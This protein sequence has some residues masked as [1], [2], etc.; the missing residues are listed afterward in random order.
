[1]SA[2][3]TPHKLR[4]IAPEIY[5]ALDALKRTGWVENDVANPESAKEHTDAL[6][7]LAQ[8][9]ID[10]LTE[11]EK[12]GLL[13]MLEVH[14]WP[15]AVHGDEVILAE[16]PEEEKTRTE[17]KFENEKKA[18][19]EIC[20]GLPQGDDIMRVWMRFETSTD[21]AAVFARELDKYQALEKAFEYEEEQ[22]IALFDE[23][24]VYTQNYIQHP[25]LLQ[26]MKNLQARRSQQK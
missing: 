6:I 13:E 4:T 26:R 17:I 24:L 20:A 21:P 2:H 25:V 7:A 8:E 19:E 9:L 3:I 15:E 5:E 10:Q 16:H 11:E 1:M 23:F 12:D 18:L 14:D 22:G